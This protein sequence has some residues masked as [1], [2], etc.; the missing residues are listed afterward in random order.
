TGSPAS[1]ST[2]VIAGVGDVLASDNLAGYTLW[3]DGN[4]LFNTD[5]ILNLGANV[6]NRGGILLQSSNGGYQSNI[7]T[8]SHT[9]TNTGTITAA[10]GSGGNR[11]VSG[12]LDNQG[13]VAGGNDYLEITG[14]YIAD[15]GTILGAGYLFNCTLR[16]AAS[17]S[18]PSTIT[19]TG[20]GVALASDNLAGYT[21]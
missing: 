20:Q 7:A 10:L 1:A 14:T 13:I 15:A 19:A 16:E 17:P 4:G 2:I 5:A 11:I 6:T 18:S 12:T 3:V 8:G 9:L 21:L